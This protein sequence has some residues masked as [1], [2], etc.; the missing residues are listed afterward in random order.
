MIWWWNNLFTWDAFLWKVFFTLVEK[1]A[2]RLLLQAGRNQTVVA[3]GLGMGLGSLWKSELQKKAYVVIFLRRMFR[4]L[5]WRSWDGKSCIWAPCNHKRI[6]FINP[7]CTFKAISGTVFVW[8]LT[9]FLGLVLGIAW[10]SFS[11]IT[12][13]SHG[14]LPRCLT[15]L[16]AGYYFFVAVYYVKY[17]NNGDA[18]IWVTQN[19]R[20]ASN[21]RFPGA[22]MLFSPL[23]RR[24]FSLSLSLFL[25]LSGKAF[26]CNFYANGGISNHPST[27]M[28][29]VAQTLRLDLFRL[30]VLLWLSSMP[31][32]ASKIITV[33]QWLLIAPLG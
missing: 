24:L 10:N 6:F 12:L 7:I 31:I 1:S 27:G 5:V 3:S 20:C 32:C 17:N 21:P 15:L 9:Y 33:Q 14:F 30:Q 19:L 23:R 25:S 26:F 8:T 13:L 4:T 2:G 11:L 18:V 29:W 22:H 28:L 16:F